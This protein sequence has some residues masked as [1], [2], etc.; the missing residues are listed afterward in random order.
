[1]C[2]RD[3]LGAV[4]IEGQ[5]PPF[6]LIAEV[7]RHDEMCIRD[8]PKKRPG[9]PLRVFKT[10]GVFCLWTASLVFFRIGLLPQGTVGDALSYLA[11]QFRG[12]SPAAFLADTSAAVQAGF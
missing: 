9:L 7:Q 11:R 8:R 12:W 5:P 3:S 10:A 6:H 2:I 4:E 1:M